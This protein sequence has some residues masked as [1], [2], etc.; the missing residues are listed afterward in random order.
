[1]YIMER[2]TI[3]TVFIKISLFIL[4][5]WTCQFNNDLVLLYYLAC[6]FKKNMVNNY[7]H[8][9]KL[10]TK[11]YRIPSKSIQDKYLCIEGLKDEVGNNR[12]RVVNRMSNNEKRDLVKRKQLNG[13]SSECERGIKQTMKN[14]SNIFETKKYSYLEKKIFKELDYIYFLKNNRTISDK[15]YKKIVRKKLALRISLP[16]V[17]LLLLLLSLILD[18]SGSYGLRKG[19]FKILNVASIG[20]Y[21]KLQDFLKNSTLGVFFKLVVK[22]E[23][24]EVNNVVRGGVRKVKIVQVDWVMQFMEFLIYFTLFFI[25]FVTII[26]AVIYHHK[27]VKK[28]QKI[29][30]R[31]R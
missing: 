15:T 18:F 26:T 9:R 12:I 24:K 20:W 28:F 25:L 27:K 8:D 13:N 16:L 30:Y 11:S 22:E 14:K 3:I 1:M 17:L 23:V 4:I 6:I 5:T 10:T 2:S 7:I 29:K 19:L 31:K 21:A